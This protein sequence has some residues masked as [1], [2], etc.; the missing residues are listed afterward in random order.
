MT[1]KSITLINRS[2]D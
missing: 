1:L 2:Q